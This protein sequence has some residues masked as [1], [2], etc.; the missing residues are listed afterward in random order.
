MMPNI[1]RLEAAVLKRLASS[2]SLFLFDH[3]LRAAGRLAAWGLA[4]RGSLSYY[5]FH[6]TAAGKRLVRAFCGQ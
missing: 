3:D 1:T 2:A 5:Q 6:A 4:K